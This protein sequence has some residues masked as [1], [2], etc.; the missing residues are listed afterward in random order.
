MAV[1][2]R[3]RQAKMHRERVRSSVLQIHWRRHANRRQTPAEAGSLDQMAAMAHTLLLL[4]FTHM[5]GMCQA[6]S[7]P[8]DLAAAVAAVVDSSSLLHY[9]LGLGPFLSSGGGGGGSSGGSTAAS[10]PMDWVHM[11]SPLQQRMD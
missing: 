1:S 2:V 5:P 3:I 7:T 8:C 4:Q 10:A 11:I 6:H 9:S